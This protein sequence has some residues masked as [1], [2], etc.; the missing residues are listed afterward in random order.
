MKRVK[1]ECHLM[2]IFFLISVID[3]QEKGSAKIL[4]GIDDINDAAEVIIVSSI[5]PYIC[6]FFFPFY[7]SPHLTFVILMLLIG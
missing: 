1:C 4:Y 6:F 5:F 2:R 7:L 3:F